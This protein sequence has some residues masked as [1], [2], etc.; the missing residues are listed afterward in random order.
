MRKILVLIGLLTLV[1]SAEARAQVST[2]TDEGAFQLALGLFTVEDFEGEAIRT[3][4]ASDP[5]TFNYGAGT[6]TL[7]RGQIVGNE[8]PSDKDPVNGS[9]AYGYYPNSHGAGGRIVFSS[10]V[11]GFGA[12]LRDLDI[13]SWNMSFLRGGE[14]QFTTTLAYNGNGGTYYRG[15]QAGTGFEFDEIS[16][17]QRSGDWITY[18]D[19]TVSAAPSAVV[20]EPETFILLATGLL[21]LAWVARRRSQ[22]E[23]AL[24]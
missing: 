17:A 11:D 3:L 16:L 19:M 13:G 6:A 21:A 23:A 14:V 15:F 20:P 4:S 12:Y 8:Q 7:D 5:F 1:P 22:A 10:L 9:G 24:S 18:D 2:Y